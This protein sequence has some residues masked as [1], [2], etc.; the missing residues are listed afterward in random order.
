MNY[1]L[2]T[3]TRCPKCPAFK[4]FVAENVTFSGEVLDEMSPDFPEKSMD[5]GITVAPTI[6]VF[7]EKG[8]EIFRA[9]ETDELDGF[10]KDLD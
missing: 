4:E 3:T 6:V 8:S 10:L 2:F 7:N 9:N 5:L 1:L